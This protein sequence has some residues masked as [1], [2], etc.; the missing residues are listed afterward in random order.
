MRDATVRHPGLDLMRSAAILLVM[1]EHIRFVAEAAWPGHRFYLP[2][3]G[4]DVFFVLS[5]FLVGDI[6]LRTVQ[7]SPVLLSALRLFWLRRLWRIWPLYYFFLLL[8]IGAVA[9][10]LQPGM[11][12]RGVCTYFFFAQNLVK[13]VDL[14]FWE[15]WSLCVEELFYFL[16]PLVFVLTLRLTLSPHQR[17]G[18]AAIFLIGAGW[19]Y[20]FFLP[21]G[22]DYDL[23]YRKMA[24]GRLDAIGWGVLG[25]AI[26]NFDSVKKL[27][28]RTLAILVPGVA[29]AGAAWL[30]GMYPWPETWHWIAP[31]VA[32]VALAMTLP[33]FHAI[34]RLPLWLGIGVERV[35]RWSYAAYLVHLSWVAWPIRVWMPIKPSP[36]EALLILVGY[37]AATFGLAALLHHTVERYF[38]RFRPSVFEGR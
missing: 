12:G 30:S 33:A 24:P 10:G 29:G 32:P 5:G 37:A 6:W 38:M 27:K 2:P 7:H 13:P 4:V 36:G 20:R 9:A 23:W 35:A 18:V 16:L 11:L 15:S 14:F 22:L 31:G 28:P 25:A 21:E 34:R 26:K 1:W 19:C 17:L 8:N 3:D